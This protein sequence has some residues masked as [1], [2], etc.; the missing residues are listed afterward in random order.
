MLF[1]CLASLKGFT[2]FLDGFKKHG[3]FRVLITHLKLHVWGPDTYVV[4]VIQMCGFAGV[5]VGGL[6]VMSLDTACACWW[7]LVLL[8]CVRCRCRSHPAS[9]QDRWCVMTKL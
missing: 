6:A 8:L 3:S 1:T 7:A 5:A 9:K 4:C 2:G